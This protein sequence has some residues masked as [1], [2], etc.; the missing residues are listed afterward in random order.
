MFFK[1]LFS[2]KEKRA[3]EPMHGADTRET[4]AGQDDARKHMESEVADDRARRGATDVR[5]GSGHSPARDPDR[6]VRATPREVPAS[7]MR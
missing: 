5:P 3:A 7:P 2:R 4:Q 1:R 6:S